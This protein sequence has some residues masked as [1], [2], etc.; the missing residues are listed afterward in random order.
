MTKT[1]LATRIEEISHRM[2]DVANDIVETIGH[3]AALRAQARAQVA[4]ALYG[5]IAAFT[6]RKAAC[7]RARRCRGDLSVCVERARAEA[8]ALSGGP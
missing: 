7:R 1:E 4:A 3:R 8:R 5:E 2:L 6:C